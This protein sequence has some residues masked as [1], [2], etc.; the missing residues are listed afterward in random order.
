MGVPTMTGLGQRGMSDWLVIP[1]VIELHSIG[2]YAI[3]GQI[4]VAEWE[5]K[6]YLQSDLVDQ[7]GEKIGYSLWQ[8]HIDWVRSTGRLT[9]LGEDMVS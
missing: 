6:F 2:P 1:L 7:V 9:I 5:R 8:R 4:G 3:D